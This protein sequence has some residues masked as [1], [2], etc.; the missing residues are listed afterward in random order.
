MITWKQIIIARSYVL[1]GS[2]IGEVGR[3]GLFHK[4]SLELG[5]IITNKYF[6]FFDG[7]LTVH[8]SIDFFKLPT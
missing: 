4:R 2:E 6:N 7:F 3:D 5:R 8:H 1:G